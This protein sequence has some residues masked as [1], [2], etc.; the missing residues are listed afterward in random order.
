[1]D[2]K[3]ESLNATFFVFLLFAHFRRVLRPSFFIPFFFAVLT[4]SIPP[5]LLFSRGCLTRVSPGRGISPNGGA[6]RAE[7]PSR[8]G[9]SRR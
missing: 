6:I 8:E 4:N 1:M 7:A 2:Y 3:K 9:R 5:A